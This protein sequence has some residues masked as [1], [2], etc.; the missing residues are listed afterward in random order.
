MKE[1]R[2]ER[3]LLLKCSASFPFTYRS[4]TNVCALCVLLLGV[5]SLWAKTIFDWAKQKCKRDREREQK[6]AHRTSKIF[7]GCFVWQT[8]TWTKQTT[9]RKRSKTRKEEK[10]T[11]S[12][13]KTPQNLRFEHKK[14]NEA[15]T[16]LLAGV[17]NIKRDAINEI[18]CTAH[19]L[20]H[21]YTRRVQNKHEW[22]GA[23]EREGEHWNGNK[24]QFRMYLEL[25]F[26][27]LALKATREKKHTKE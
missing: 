8:W 23:R 22:D 11:K 27:L 13:K 2:A 7:F 24:N 26:F 18:H 17:N 10:R 9:H 16:K 19:W 6:K 14:Y 20:R 25:A 15:T 1:L 3:K 4:N 21:I 12:R 5:S